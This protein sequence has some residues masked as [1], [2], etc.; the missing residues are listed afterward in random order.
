MKDEEYLGILSCYFDTLFSIRVR[1]LSSCSVVFSPRDYLFALNGYWF[2]F[3]LL[4]SSLAC[5]A[6][7]LGDIYMSYS[8]L[9]EA[10]MV[11]DF[12]PLGYIV[13]LRVPILAL[14]AFLF[15]VMTTSC[16][17]MWPLTGTIFLPIALTAALLLNPFDFKYYVIL[18]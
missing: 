11:P 14:L 7:S 16:C 10:N 2:C 8:K 12:A 4:S 15:N 17:S 5:M 3:L 1:L 9:S 13:C 18:P 6:I